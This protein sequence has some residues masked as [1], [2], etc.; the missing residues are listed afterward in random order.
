MLRHIRIISKNFRKIPHPG[1]ETWHNFS[2]EVSKLTDKQENL[3]FLEP[4]YQH[5]RNATE[6][7][8]KDISSRTG[9]IPIFVQFQ[10]G[11][12]P[13]NRLTDI[14]EIWFFLNLNDFVQGCYIP[15]FRV[16]A[17]ILPDFFQLY[18]SV[19]E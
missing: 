1:Q 10:Q 17:S 6:N 13:T 16:L 15:S 3:N 5:P 18:T 8:Q 19:K 2:K 7:F 9:D 14:Q 11:S 4:V 12:K